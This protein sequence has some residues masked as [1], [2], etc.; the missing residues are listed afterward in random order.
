MNSFI[1]GEILKCVKKGKLWGRTVEVK[2]W[3]ANP[4]S[5]ICEVFSTGKE[6]LL[7][8]NELQTVFQFDMEA[9][10]LWK[11]IENG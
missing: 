2:K 9:L 3:V 11:E 8:A 1:Q 6:V 7:F 10:A 4:S 5:Y